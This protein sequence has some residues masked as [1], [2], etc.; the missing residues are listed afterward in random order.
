MKR[1][2][3][4][5][6]L[7]NGNYTRFQFDCPVYL[8]ANMGYCF[9]VMC[10]DAVAKAQISKMGEYDKFHQCWVSSQPYPVG[11]MLSPANASSWT[12]HQDMDLTFRLLEATFTGASR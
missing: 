5:N 8:E 9:V 2:A 4:A 6:V 10:N 11:I 12:A 3:A 7:T 1:V